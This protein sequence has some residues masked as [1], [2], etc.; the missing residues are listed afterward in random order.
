M[1][2]A[3]WRHRTFDILCF[4]F[5][6]RWL[7]G[8]KCPPCFCGGSAGLQTS[9][10]RIT[11]KDQ[12]A[13]GSTRRDRRAHRARPPNTSS[14]NIRLGVRHHVSPMPSFCQMQMTSSRF[15]LLLKDKT[16]RS[17]FSESEGA[18]VTEMR[19]RFYGSWIGLRWRNAAARTVTRGEHAVP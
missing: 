4:R 19:G 8:V 18:F 16:R 11:Y 14:D 13:S 3:F 2:V 7:F 5:R 12:H 6:K 17:V 15:E 9:S 10:F 1:F